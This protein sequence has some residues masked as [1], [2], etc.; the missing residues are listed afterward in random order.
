ME[1]TRAFRVYQP[2]DGEVW[3]FD[4]VFPYARV[5]AALPEG[6]SKDQLLEMWQGHD[7]F[8]RRVALYGFIHL[9]PTEP[10][11]QQVVA[12]ALQGYLLGD[13]ALYWIKTR[14]A[15][16]LALVVAESLFMRRTLH[17]GQRSVALE[18][19]SHLGYDFRPHEPLLWD[20]ARQ[21]PTFEDITPIVA[22][23]ILLKMQRPRAKRLLSRFLRTADQRLLSVGLRILRDHAPL[24]LIADEIMRLAMRLSPRTH[25]LFACF[26][27]LE[28]LLTVPL[29][30]RWLQQLCRQLEAWRVADP[31]AHFTESLRYFQD[32][33]LTRRG[34]P[35]GGGRLVSSN[36]PDPANVPI[37][38]A[39]VRRLLG[40]NGDTQP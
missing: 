5:K 10:I 24:S 13:D 21:R 25:E 22:I 23:A 32:G 17:D 3:H 11:A 29:S 30:E 26:E 16:P 37:M 12:Q 27:T 38:E 33:Y 6:A 15:H 40:Q 4:G 14:Q 8:N 39:C 28:L 2:Y 7:F 9:M 19:L 36:S 31:S 18:T 1:R 35:L 34:Y 20:W